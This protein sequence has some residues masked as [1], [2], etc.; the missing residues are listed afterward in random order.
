MTAS[1][2]PSNC[3]LI[4]RSDPPHPSARPTTPTATVCPD[5]F[6]VRSGTLVL[7][8]DSPLANGGVD[9]DDSTGPAGRPHLRR[10]R[11]LP[12]RARCDRTGHAR[13]RLGRRRGARLPRDLQGLRSLRPHGRDPARHASHRRRARHH[14]HRLPGPHADRQLPLPGRRAGPRG[15]LDLPLVA[16]RTADLRRDHPDPRDHGRGLRPRALL[17]GA[18]PCRSTPRSPRRSSAMP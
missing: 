2:T 4:S 12:D 9:S 13:D 17:R 1:R 6:E 5:Y 10:A 18:R 8:A 11:G 7:N 3:L 15:R 14:R 16:R